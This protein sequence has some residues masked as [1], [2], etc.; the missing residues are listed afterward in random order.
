MRDITTIDVTVKG[1]RALLQNDCFNNGTT[2]TK[3][4]K[5]QVYDPQK[6]AEKRL[7][8]DDDK[9]LCQKATHFEASMVKSAAEFKFQGKKTYKDVV[10]AGV[11]ITPLLIPHKYLEWKIRSDPVV[12]NRARV[13]AWRPEIPEGWELDFNLHIRDDRLEPLVAKQI[14]ENA[15]LYYGIGDWRPKFGLFEVIFWEVNDKN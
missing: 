7:I 8:L 12:I 2:T 5:G 15:G 1:I 13:I 11:E 9:R 4:K 10:K 3:A 6:E 14:L